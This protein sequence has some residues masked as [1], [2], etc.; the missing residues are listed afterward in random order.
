MKK[1]S[2]FTKCK[3]E[4]CNN[5][6]INRGMCPKH[7]QAWRRYGSPIASSAQYI[8]EPLDQA[9]K[10]LQE[11]NQSSLIMSYPNQTCPYCGAQRVGTLIDGIPVTHLSNCL[12]IRVGK[13]LASSV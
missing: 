10:L 6:A 4:F 3:V 5:Q 11:F 12:Y 8:K 9:I 13:F 7:Y 2:V 1:R